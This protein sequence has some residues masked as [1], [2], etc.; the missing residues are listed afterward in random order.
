MK[1]IL[2]LIVTLVVAPLAL[3]AGCE[4]GFFSKH[5]SHEQLFNNLGNYHH[6]IST[7]VPMAQRYFDQGLTLTYAFNHDEA[8]RSFEEAARLDPDCAI[9]YW[10]EALVLGPNIN[11]PMDPS[12]NE[13]ANQ[14]V[15]KA[16][17]AAPN[18]GANEQAY[19]QA[20]THRYAEN[21]PDDRL[22]LD[23]DYAN[24]MREVVKQFPDD[25]DAATLFAEALMD[26]TPWAYW[27][28][29]GKPTQYTNE[30]VSTLESVLARN[31]NH[32]GANHYYIH[33]V[34]ASQTPDRAIPSAERL[35]SLVPGA[36]HLVHMPAHTFWRVG[37]YHDAAVAN[38]H[39][40]HADESYMP[41]M[42]MQG[43]YLTAYYPHNIHFLFAASAIE[44]NSTEAIQ[45]ARK[46]VAE[47]PASHYKD[48]PPI[49]DF[50]PMPLFALVRFGKWDEI[51]NEPQ[52]S[53]Q[54]RYTTGMWHY[55][56]GLAYVRKDQLQEA[57]DEL[58]KLTQIAN[59]AE[60]KQFPLASGSTADVMLKIALLIVGG[61]LA[62]AQGNSDSLIS[63]LKQA[64]E[65]QDG[66]AYTEPPAWYY[67]VR[68]SLGAALLDAGRASEAEAVYREDLK[69]YP[70]NGWSLYGLMLSLEKQ[71]KTTE[72]VQIKT[73]FDEAWRWADVTLSASRF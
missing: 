15:R 57:A 70:R 63:Q 72:A 64:V 41:D 30:I 39:A 10:G 62:G 50:M 42:N 20:L 23:I 59:S 19:I 13:K 37:R 17:Q 61:E 67:P 73:Q 8:F 71:N 46:L 33:A 21:P 6:V 3:L 55:A 35:P 31:Q 48:F 5:S 49:E 32:P 25:I 54:Y 47:I 52:P 45:A 7:K 53:S 65:L 56:R 40:I 29:D 14:L 16:L 68:Q 51:L 9:C 38:E 2:V 44:G 22:S 4:S 58:N 66:L 43:W 36:G 1:S 18:A 27:T 60:M 12:L 26:V 28:K 11:A 69:I 34:E 24:A